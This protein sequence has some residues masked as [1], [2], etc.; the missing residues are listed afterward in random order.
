MKKENIKKHKKIEIIIFAILAFISTSVLLDQVF[1]KS[2]SFEVKK[3][4]YK[5]YIKDSDTGKYEEQTSN[6]FPGEGYYL[7]I[8]KTNEEC[9]TGKVDQN[10][11]LSIQALIRFS[12]SYEEAHSNINNSNI[13]SVLD[14]WYFGIFENKMVENYISDTLFC[15]DRKTLPDAQGYGTSNTLYMA[16]NRLVSNKNPSL[17][18]TQKN[19]SFTKDDNTFGNGNLTY[20]I[21]LISADEAAFAGLVDDMTALNNYLIK[22]DSYFTMTPNRVAE[23][24]AGYIPKIFSIND[25]GKLYN[26]ASANNEYSVAPVININKEAVKTLTGTGTSTDPFVVH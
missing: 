10:D 23:T 5:F 21:G 17:I 6:V 15:N 24:T 26:Y 2:G 3:T 9:S 25:T 18:C 8:D 14:T 20:S 11:D 7:N 16:N 19:D 13:K 22:N 1:K 4:E 12:T